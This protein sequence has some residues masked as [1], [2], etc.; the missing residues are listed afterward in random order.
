LHRSNQI[1]DSVG[2]GNTA[3]HFFRIGGGIP[4][5]DVSDA[6]HSLTEGLSY[7]NGAHIRAKDFNDIPRK[8]TLLD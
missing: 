8:S 5:D 7:F 2:I 4:D 6:E 3:G 1:L